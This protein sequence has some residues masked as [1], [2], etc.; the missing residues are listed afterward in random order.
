MDF[1]E[2]EKSPLVT[3]SELEVDE[4]G[5]RRSIEERFPRLSAEKVL[6]DIVVEQCTRQPTKGPASSW[7]GIMIR[8]ARDEPEWEGV[9][10][11][12]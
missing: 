10:K 1:N 11:A 7:A 6:G 4:G 3:E 2:L 12:F 9:N 8:A 5:Y